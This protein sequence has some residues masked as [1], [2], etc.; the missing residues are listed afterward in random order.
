V[1]DDKIAQPINTEQAS[2]KGV[3]IELSEDAIAS[4]TS[5]FDVLI[6]MDLEQANNL[7]KE[8]ESEQQENNSESKSDANHKQSGGSNKC[9]KERKSKNQR[10]S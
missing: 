7:M 1:S 6:Q 2:S 3:S 9:D 4:L 5:Y 8:N 10:Q